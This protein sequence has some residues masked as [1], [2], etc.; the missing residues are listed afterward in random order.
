[1]KRLT[2]LTMMSLALIMLLTPL[3]Q[4]SSQGNLTIDM[5]IEGECGSIHNYGENLTVSISLKGGPASVTL[6]VEL[7]DKTRRILKELNLTKGTYEVPLNLSNA[8]PGLWMLHAVAVSSEGVQK[9]V[10]CSVF[11]RGREI[12]EGP[13]KSGTKEFELVSQN[14]TARIINLPSDIAVGGGRELLVEIRNR[15]DERRS[16]TI[17]C[18]GEGATCIPD[19]RS[20]IVDPHSNVTLGFKVIFT[21]EG[22]RSLIIALYENNSLVLSREFTITVVGTQGD[23]NMNPE[24]GR[25]VG[26]GGDM[27]T[28]NSPARPSPQNTNPTI[29]LTNTGTNESASGWG[30]RVNNGIAL[31]SIGV[32]LIIIIIVLT[33]IARKKKSD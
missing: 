12:P 29:T 27:I 20:L 31:I 9:S 21:L 22:N 17:T 10:V 15:G 4:V 30:T 16:L 24:A 19:Q 14:M 25:S 32:L 2:V 6:W 13:P 23:S 11:V 18:G 7:P 33:R 26:V 3:F 1:M 5:T 8:P 28:T